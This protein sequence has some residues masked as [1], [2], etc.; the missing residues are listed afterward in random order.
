MRLGAS[1]TLQ[2]LGGFSGSQASITWL[3]QS[4][5]AEELYCPTLCYPFC[6]C[7]GSLFGRSIHAVSLPLGSPIEAN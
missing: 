2:S 4:A 1:Q 7:I 3:S 5:Q 6:S